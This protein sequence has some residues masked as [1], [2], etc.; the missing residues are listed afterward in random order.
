MKYL[1]ITISVVLGLS[2]FTSA[3]TWSTLP[4]MPTIKFAEGAVCL[5]DKIYVVTDDTMQ[6]YNLVTN[7]WSVGGVLNYF[8]GEF[9][10]T[11]CNGK[12]Y[13]IGGFNN[14]AKNYIEEYDPS[15]DTWT[16]KTPM[17]ISRSQLTA[18]SANGLVYVMGGWP[19][20]L[21][22]VHEFNPSTN[23]WSV[24]EPLEL[25]RKQRNGAASINDKIYFMGGGNTFSNVSYS[26]LNEYN[27]LNDVWT[28]KTSM[29]QALYGGSAVVL[30]GQ[31]HYLGGHTGGQGINPSVNSHFI[32]NPVNDTWTN[33]IPLTF[34]RFYHVAVNANGKIHLIGGI[35]N[36]NEYVNIHEVL[37]LCNEFVSITPQ[38]NEL[39][40]GSA[41]N[42]DV[43]SNQPNASYLWQSDFGQGFQTLNNFGNYSGTN[44]ST[45]IIENIQLQNHNQPFRVIVSSGECIDTSN[46]ATITI[47]DTCVTSI[48]DTKFIMVTDTLVI[49]TLITGI[50]PPN[51]SNTI[52][53]YPNPANS[54]ITIDYGDFVIM[55]GYQLRIENSLGQQV[56]QTEITQQIDYLTLDTWAG[57][58]LY[59]VHIVDPQG[60]TIDIR[61]II[62]Q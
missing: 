33:G 20:N 25:G 23:T 48:N 56:F 34:E 42:F 55:N 3:Q 18:S 29:P 59:F 57:N 53:V 62:L 47:L 1:L 19:S 10:V 41:A 43:S 15:N 8:R 50:N 44:S 39:G 14:G 2:A 13:A 12:I 60:N 45:L 32:Y 11:E 28:N 54:H 6:I 46:V 9:A 5:N 30:N 24:K 37:N 51:N 58:G 17:P 36:D 49:N 38:I 7:T 27:S 61:K 35:N 16:I 40:I 22:V 52:K 26:N 21:N 31:I 4:S